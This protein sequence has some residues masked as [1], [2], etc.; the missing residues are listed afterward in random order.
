MYFPDISGKS[1]KGEVTHTTDL[2][3]GKVSLL[4]I[5]SARISEV[6]LLS[7]GSFCH[8]GHMPRNNG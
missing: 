1:L 2:L 7:A 6:C 4:S 8:V 5:V 3:K